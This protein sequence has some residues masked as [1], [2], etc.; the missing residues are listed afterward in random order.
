MPLSNACVLLLGILRHSSVS[1]R[2]EEEEEA[3][4]G[5]RGWSHQLGSSRSTVG[6]VAGA[7]PGDNGGNGCWGNACWHTWVSSRKGELG[8]DPRMLRNMNLDSS[9]RSCVML[10]VDY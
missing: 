5:E 4:E 7:R 9:V 8:S 6:P 10:R 1:H 3:K 2:W